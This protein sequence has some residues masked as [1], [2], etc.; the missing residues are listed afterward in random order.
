MFFN[1]FIV[2]R[3]PPWRACD[4]FDSIYS[5][6]GEELSQEELNPRLVLVHIQELAKAIY[7]NENISLTN[8]QNYSQ[9][10]PLPTEGHMTRV[11]QPIFPSLDPALVSKI[12][13]E[14]MIEQNKNLTTASS[15]QNK[16]VPLGQ[17]LSGDHN[18]LVPNSARRLEVLRNCITN[19]FENKI[20]DAKKTFPAVIRALKN[21]AAR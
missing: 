9:R 10:I 6:L 21:K 1:D 16:L 3:G 12:I 19:I 5:S 20:S 15:S 17:R 14:N 2:T 13:Q 11:H 18:H 7:N 8:G 4:I